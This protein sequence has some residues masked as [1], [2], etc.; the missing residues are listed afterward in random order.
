MRQRLHVYAQNK[1]YRDR[2]N[3]IRSG[4]VPICRYIP[5]HNS[6]EFLVNGHINGKRVRRF[7]EVEPSE[8]INRLTEC[9]T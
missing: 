2:N 7:I 4:N 3:F 5:D 6:F 1:I 9:L 8:F